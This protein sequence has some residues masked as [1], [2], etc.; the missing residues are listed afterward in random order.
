ME[1]AFDLLVHELADIRNAEETILGMLEKAASAATNA[2]LRKGLEAHQAQTQGH[3]ENVDAAFEA[4]GMKPQEVECKGA[5]GLKE[6]LDEA[7]KEKPA[8]EVLDT[9]IAGGAAKTEQYEITAYTG[10]VD[11]AKQLGHDDVAKLLSTNLK[12]EEETLKKVEKLEQKLAKALPAP[13]MN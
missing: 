13:S 12:E 8:S 7:I 2:D 3:L 5:K 9:M 10:M 11:L 6:E 1:N 4:L